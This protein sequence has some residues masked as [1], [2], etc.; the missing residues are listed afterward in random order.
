M[1]AH[2][3]ADASFSDLL[4][5]PAARTPGHQPDP[6]TRT[7]THPHTHTPTH[8]HTSTPLHLSSM[9]GCDL[10]VPRSFDAAIAG[11][12]FVFHCAAPVDLNCPRA[13]VQE[14]LWAPMVEGTANVLGSCSMAG[15]VEAVVMTSG[16]AAVVA[17]NH[18]R[19]EGGVCDLASVAWLPGL[20]A[21][22]LKS[23]LRSEVGIS[24]LQARTMYSPRPTGI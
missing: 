19:G 4:L 2:P 13:R 11:A 21:V 5:H 17:D 12:R 6:H 16:V 8:P 22:M 20:L 18:E 9:Q 14:V 15:S 1:N 7:P 3:C 24:P 23:C 10:V